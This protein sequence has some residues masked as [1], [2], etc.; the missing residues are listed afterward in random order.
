MCLCQRVD[1]V[2]AFGRILQ[3]RQAV[4]VPSL[5]GWKG[6][7]I[8]KIESTFLYLWI[9]YSIRCIFF[10]SKHY[11]SYVGS[12]FQLPHSLMWVKNVP[13]RIVCI[14]Y[15]QYTVMYCNYMYM[16][17]CSVYLCIR[18]F[19]FTSLIF[20]IFM[21][22]LASSF[23]FCIRC[24]FQEIDPSCLHSS[25]VLLLPFILFS[26]YRFDISI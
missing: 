8:P 9:L 15:I 26:R 10:P 16:L 25:T 4:R 7:F 5:H 19:E 22:V 3:Y 12:T 18:I 21:F 17:Y 2:L 6:N 1:G 24:H 13:L 14:T 20:P 11:Y 23:Q